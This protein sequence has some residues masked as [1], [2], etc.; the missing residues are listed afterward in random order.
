MEMFIITIS[1]TI[2]GDT[3]SHYIPKILDRIIDYFKHKKDRPE[4]E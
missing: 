1:A 4:C 3:I 2:I